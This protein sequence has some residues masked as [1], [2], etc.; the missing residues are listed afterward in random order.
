MRWTWTDSQSEEWAL[1]EAWPGGRSA[2]LRTWVVRGSCAACGNP[3]EALDGADFDALTG[4]T[5]GGDLPDGAA[6]VAT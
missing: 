1:T 5:E 2:V 4:W 6:E 3:K